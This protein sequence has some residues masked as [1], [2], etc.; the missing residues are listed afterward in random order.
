MPAKNK[1]SSQR[2]NTEIIVRK[3]E[4]KAQ[5]IN[6]FVSAK[7]SLAKRVTTPSRDEKTKNIVYRKPE[8]TQ[9]V[10]QNILYPNLNNIRISKKTLEKTK[11]VD[12]YNIKSVKIFSVQRCG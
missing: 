8:T 11:I 6:Q 3:Q 2:S 9:I 12:H 5:V 7:K 1:N 10:M 4:S